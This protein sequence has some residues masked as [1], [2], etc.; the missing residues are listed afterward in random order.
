M[1]I[2]FSEGLEGKE[3]REARQKEEG[4]QTSFL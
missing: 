3:N 4:L 1:K 2:I